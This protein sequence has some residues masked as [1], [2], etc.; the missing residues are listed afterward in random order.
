MRRYDMKTLFNLMI[1]I[2]LIIA[3]L[4]ITLQVNAETIYHQT[5]P[6]TTF[7]D[8]SKPSIVVQ[9]D[10]AYQTYPGTTFRDYT[11][12]GII[13]ERNQFYEPQRP[14]WNQPR[15]NQPVQQAPWL[16]HVWAPQ[17]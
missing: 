11:K 17:D 6:G 3:A 5:Y 2:S 13:I 4:S 16:P 7:R 1:I 12:P 10:Q 14:V 15:I 8:Y 9:G